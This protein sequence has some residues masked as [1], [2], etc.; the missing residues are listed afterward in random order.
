MVRVLIVEDEPLARFVGRRSLEDLGF[1]VIEAETC[2]RAIELIE[3][4]RFD[5]VVIDHRLP[6]GLGIDVVRRLRNRERVMSV[7]YLSA[8]AEQITPAIQEELKIDAV[9]A[10]PV[11]AEDLKSVMERIARRKGE[12]AGVECEA[13]RDEP[14]SCGRFILVA[15]PQRLQAQGVRD[16]QASVCD[17][18]WLGL[19]LRP[20]ETIDEEAVPELIKLAGQCRGRGGRLCLIGLRSELDHELRVKGVDRECDLLP[21]LQGLESRGRRLSAACERTSLLDS[22]IRRNRHDQDF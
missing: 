16:F 18:P 21:T 8:E 19:N 1:L 7:V 12:P 10:K 3:T 15:G 2:C 22:S 5:T 6:D 11:G 9:L 4:V 20:T 13:G 17:N 14:T